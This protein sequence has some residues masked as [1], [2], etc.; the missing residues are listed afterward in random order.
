MS[1]AFYSFLL[2]MMSAPMT[3]GIQPKQVRIKTI[4]IDPQPRSITAS[5]GKIIANSTWRQDIVVN[6]FVR[7]KVMLAE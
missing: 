3:P 2:R 7:Q 6:L 1:F 4:V 5:G